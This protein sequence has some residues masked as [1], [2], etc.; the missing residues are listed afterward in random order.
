MNFFY[1][2]NFDEP[3]FSKTYFFSIFVGVLAFSELQ[4]SMALCF[5]FF[6]NNSKIKCPLRKNHKGHSVWNKEKYD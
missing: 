2:A 3:R 6:L 1:F 4:T 5:G